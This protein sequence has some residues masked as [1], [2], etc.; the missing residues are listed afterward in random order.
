[1]AQNSRDNRASQK[2]RVS[3]LNISCLSDSCAVG[4]KMVNKFLVNTGSRLQ[5][6][7][8]DEDVFMTF[9]KRPPL[10]PCILSLT[11]A[12]GRDI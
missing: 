11:T 6:C 12:D 10:K 9:E 5:V 1:M 8:I 4:E 3:V 7:L 2:L